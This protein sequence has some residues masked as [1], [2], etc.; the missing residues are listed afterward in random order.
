MSGLAFD[1]SV[2]EPSGKRPGIRWAWSERASAFTATVS[3]APAF[4]LFWMSAQF[5]PTFFMSRC[6][7]A[8]GSPVPIVVFVAVAQPTTASAT[9]VPRI[10]AVLMGR[11]IV[12]AP[13][14]GSGLSSL[15]SLADL[16]LDRRDRLEVLRDREAIV[17]AQVLVAGQGAVDDL[18]HQPAGD[19]A[20]GL[21]TRAEIFCDLLLGPLQARR[22]VGG[23][24]RD[25]RVLGALG[26][27][28]E[29]AGVVGRHRH[30]ARRVALA[31]VGDGADEILAARDAGGRHRRRRILARRK[32]RE[33]RGQE[34]ALEH[35]DRDPL[36]LIGPLD[37]RHRAQED[38]KSVV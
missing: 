34:H 9:R 27:A 33:P 28:R 17:L 12:S 2:S 5:A 26:V 13:P 6:R 8:T 18:A 31:A 30:R 11:S 7:S 3:G 22:L 10:T 21:V 38:R 24:V 16:V 32:R 19:V 20:V 36:R 4:T 35:R 29:E 23:D 15:C 25:L 1:L 37:R 14:D